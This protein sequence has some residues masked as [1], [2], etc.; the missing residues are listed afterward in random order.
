MKRHVVAFIALA[1]AASM[2]LLAQGP[3][4]TTRAWNAAD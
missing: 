2:T 1:A 3:T 4:A